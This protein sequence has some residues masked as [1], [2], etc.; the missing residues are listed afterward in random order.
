M[1]D[2]F[3]LRLTNWRC[4]HHTEVSLPTTSSM[5]IDENGSGKTSVLSGL[6]SLIHRQ[7]WP[8]TKW[9]DHLRQDTD[10]FGVSTP[11]PDWYI[12][13]R[14]APSGRLQT[15]KEFPRVEVLFGK[16]LLDYKNLP[17]I[18]T[19]TPSDNYWLSQSRSSKLAQ[20]DHLIGCVYPDFVG[21]LRNLDKHVR[22]KNQYLK[23]LQEFPDQVDWPLVTIY[24]SAIYQVSRQVWQMRYSFLRFVEQK[25][26]EFG[27]WIQ[28]PSHDLNLR[29]SVS[30]SQGGRDLFN[31]SQL[32]SLDAL[33]VEPDWEILWKKELIVGKVLYGAQ[34]DDVWFEHRHQ[35]ITSMFSRGEMRLFVIFLKSLVSV[36]PD[37]ASR[38]VWWL[39]DDVYNE[40]D[41]KREQIL[42]KNILDQVQ[43]YLCTGTKI[44]PQTCVELRSN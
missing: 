3:P 18:L 25:L 6:Y 7:P 22:S 4:F 32:E 37:S 10:Y 13:G 5:I 44:P 14:I 17:I 42:Q 1:S 24:N 16:H 39:L 20:F 11:Y 36:H 33:L 21:Y 35:Q 30:N 23:Q 15:K 29:W 26:P 2:F 34:R 9:Q 41:E 31:A 43:Y 38:E 40:F 8:G 27:N 12:S 28:A 19:Y